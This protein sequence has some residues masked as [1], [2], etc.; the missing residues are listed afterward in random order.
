MHDRESI[1]AHRERTGGALVEL[2]HCGGGLDRALGH[3]QNLD[4][5]RAAGDLCLG[6]ITVLV[7]LQGWRD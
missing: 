7:I 3:Q 1:H 2:G 4:I 6:F 5:Q